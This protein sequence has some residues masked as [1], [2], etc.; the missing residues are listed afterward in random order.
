MKEESPERR[1]VPGF[2]IQVVPRSAPEVVNDA[3]ED[4]QQ[5][6]TDDNSDIVAHG[7]SPQDYSMASSG[8]FSLRSRRVE[9]VDPKAAHQEAKEKK[10][11]KK[12]IKKN[13]QQINW[14]TGGRGGKGGR[15]GRGGRGSG[16]ADL[17]RLV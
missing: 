15:G 4:M 9:R 5:Y 8:E 6:E 2:A 14:I 16:A 12:A 17:V 3:D 13:K 11:R 1:V 10:K 7:E